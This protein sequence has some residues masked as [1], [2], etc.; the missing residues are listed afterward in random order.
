MHDFTNL[1]YVQ[2]GTPE[3]LLS[4]VHKQHLYDHCLKTSQNDHSSKN[5]ESVDNLLLYYEQ[6]YSKFS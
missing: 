1:D 6:V 5:F 4:L 3:H 2:G